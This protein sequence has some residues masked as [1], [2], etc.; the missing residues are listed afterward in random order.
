ML[1][2]LAVASATTGILVFSRTR[3]QRDVD[4]EQLA[5]ELPSEG[6]EDLPCPWCYA[7]TNETDARCP[8]CGRRFG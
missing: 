7:P 4:W 6:A 1:E 2:V 8:S 3:R 5:V